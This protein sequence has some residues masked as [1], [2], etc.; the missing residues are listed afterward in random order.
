MLVESTS[1]FTAPGCCARRFRRQSQEEFEST[2]RANLSTAY[3]TVAAVV[4][5][6]PAGGRIILVSSTAGVDAGMFM[7]AYAA[8]KAAVRTMAA[9][10][11]AELEAG[12]IAVHVVLP[13]TVDTEM[14]KITEIE[15]AALRAEDVVSAGWPDSG[16]LA[17]VRR[18]TVAHL[19]DKLYHHCEDDICLGAAGWGRTNAC[20]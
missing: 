20:E 9:S 3:G 4:P 7:S 17:P 1:L 18:V 16:R 19:N 10:M 15:R 11:R 5:S 2:V 6:M 12:G 8:S 14:M 13:G